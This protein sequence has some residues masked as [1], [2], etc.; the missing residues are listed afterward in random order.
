MLCCFPFCSTLLHPNLARSFFLL[1]AADTDPAPSFFFFRPQPGARPG[2]FHFVFIDV[3]HSWSYLISPH[4]LKDFLRKMPPKVSGSQESLSSLQDGST[5]LW[6]PARRPS[7]QGGVVNWYHS[8]P[9]PLS[10]IRSSCMLYQS[11]NSFL[12]C[13]L[14]VE[15]LS[16]RKSGVQ[17][18]THHCSCANS[19]FPAS[20]RICTSLNRG[21]G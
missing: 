16:R 15:G 20:R 5:P 2:C 14:N 8:P 9:H 13:M 21:K 12:R 18:W 17:G 11:W 7:K 19:L 6:V 10:F 4:F 1:Y 3:L